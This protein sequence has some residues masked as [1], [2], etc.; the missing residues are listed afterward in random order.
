MYIQCFYSF[1]PCPHFTSPKIMTN[2]KDPIS[3]SKQLKDLAQETHLP[4]SKCHKNLHVLPMTSSLALF[5]FMLHFC[6][7]KLSMP[8]LSPY[9]RKSHNHVRTHPSLWTSCC[10][11]FFFSKHLPCSPH[12]A[13]P[14]NTSH[15]KPPLDNWSIPWTQVTTKFSIASIKLA[16]LTIRKF[17]KVIV[18]LS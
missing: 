3:Y 9:F 17:T 15:R 7:Y 11:F 13:Y 14:Q 8:T 1:W 10:K 12:L 2:P 18:N 16:R 4:S 5:S 6:W